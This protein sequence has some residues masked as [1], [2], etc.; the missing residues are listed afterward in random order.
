MLCAVCES[1]FPLKISNES[2]SW[3]YMVPKYSLFVATPRFAV[4][5]SA[6]AATVTSIS[7]PPDGRLTGPLA[8]DPSAGTM[9]C[10]DSRL[11]DQK[12]PWWAS[13]SALRSLSALRAD[14]AKGAHDDRYI[15]LGLA[16]R[17]SDR[18]FG[19]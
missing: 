10:L 1:Y 14:N 7:G 9:R 16:R 3:S 15:D 5:T 19:I 12:I 18:T 8:S 6:L 11:I 17:P 4:R 2:L 13:V